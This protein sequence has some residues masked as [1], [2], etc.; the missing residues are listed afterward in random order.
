MS[1]VIIGFDNGLSPNRRQSIVETNDDLSL[2]EHRG[3]SFSE[4]WISFFN[5]F[6]EESAFENIVCEKLAILSR[7]RCVSR[8]MIQ[9]V[10]DITI[11]TVSFLQ[12]CQ[13]NL[14]MQAFVQ[15]YII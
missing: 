6:I 10:N 2:N 3:T 15:L 7:P 13:H 8:N 5:I 9:N 14:I 11:G 4:I 12:Y 1:L